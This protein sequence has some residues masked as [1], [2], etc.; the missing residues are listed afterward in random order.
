MISRAI[1]LSLFIDIN[2]YT[3]YSEQVGKSKFVLQVIS[4]REY[5]ILPTNLK[6]E[7]ARGK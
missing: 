1:H 2:M 4:R 5:K 3:M 6:G 7:V